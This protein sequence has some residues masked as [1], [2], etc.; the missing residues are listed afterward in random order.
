MDFTNW[1]ADSINKPAMNTGMPQL[2]VSPTG[3]WLPPAFYVP[4][5]QI[6]P[7]CGW[8]PV[9]GPKGSA[10]S[11][12]WKTASKAHRE[13]WSQFM[14]HEESTNLSFSTTFGKTKERL[15]Q[16]TTLCILGSREGMQ[17]LEFWHKKEQEAWS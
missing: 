17:A 7:S 9:N 3:S 15:C 2:H 10:E 8:L 5:P 16:H 11:E 14:S 13:S 1:V 4:H 6:P 12:L